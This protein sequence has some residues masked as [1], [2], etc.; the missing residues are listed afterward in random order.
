M[1]RPSGRLLRTWFALMALSIVLAVA[2]DTTHAS[3]LGIGLLALVGAAAF[4]KARLVLAVY[5]GLR[6]APSALA[7][8][9]AA[10]G[11]ILAIVVLSF[12]IPA[13][14]FAR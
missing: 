4:L 1:F 6:V 7:G 8:F 11:A 3:R 10:V 14:L 5:L 9:S 13:Q 12:M 2:A